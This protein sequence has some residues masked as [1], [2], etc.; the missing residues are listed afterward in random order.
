MKSNDM[1]I[2]EWIENIEALYGDLV[3]RQIKLLTISSDIVEKKYGIDCKNRK[4]LILDC[5]NLDSLISVFRYSE[6]VCPGLS[7]YLMCLPGFGPQKYK[8]ILPETRRQHS[9]IYDC[10]VLSMPDRIENIEKIELIRNHFEI[11]DHYNES[12]FGVD[13]KLLNYAL[14]I[15]RLK[16]EF[17][18]EVDAS[19][20]LSEIWFDRLV[21]RNLCAAQPVITEYLQSLPGFGTGWDAE[22][23]RLNGFMLVGLRQILEDILK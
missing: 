2:V 15:A 14:D 7:D 1:L 18:A 6:N 23:K 9:F 3:G 8:E 22:S 4:G 17:G 5:A 13:I 16:V 19:M 10:L 21:S 20:I 11:N 12:Y